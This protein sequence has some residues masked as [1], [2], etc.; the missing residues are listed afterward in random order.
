MTQSISQEK[1]SKQMAAS[2]RHSIIC[3]TFECTRK[4]TQR[5]KRQDEQARL[6]EESFCEEE[7]KEYI[8]VK[9]S[10]KEINVQI[11]R[12]NKPIW[13]ILQCGVL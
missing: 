11:T 4:D 5:N 7:L 3:I 2:S 1:D 6:V 8:R 10:V 13:G 9:I 12:R